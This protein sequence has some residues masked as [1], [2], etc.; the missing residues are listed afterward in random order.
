MCG[1]A[2]T[3]RVSGC[4]LIIKTRSDA[5]ESESERRSTSKDYLWSRML[6]NRVKGFN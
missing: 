5:L 2:R 3:V 6:K 4:N 1:D